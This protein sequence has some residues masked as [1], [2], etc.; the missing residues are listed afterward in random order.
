MNSKILVYRVVNSDFFN[1]VDVLNPYSVTLY[2]RSVIIQAEYLPEKENFLIENNF[3]FKEKR[4]SFSDI[5]KKNTIFYDYEK[6]Y[7]GYKIE[8]CLTGEENDK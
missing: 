5:S 3:K 4:K 7:G 8:V 6:N 2:K 1:I